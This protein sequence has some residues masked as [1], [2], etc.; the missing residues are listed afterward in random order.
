MS[1]EQ[2]PTFCLKE[3]A[4]RTETQVLEHADKLACLRIR[5]VETPASL[6]R[7]ISDCSATPIQ[8]EERQH[9]QY[10][11]STCSFY[12][13]LVHRYENAEGC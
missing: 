8:R 7:K 3:T 5:S 2:E 9:C 6:W 4:P 13:I 10:K 11:P 1:Q 12:K